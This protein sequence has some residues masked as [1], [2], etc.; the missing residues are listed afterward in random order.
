MQKEKEQ[1]E[2]L[3]AQATTMS[4]AMAEEI[5]SKS[6]KLEQERQER[7][8]VT[9]RL[10]EIERKLLHGAQVISETQQHE[11]ILRQKEVE[12]ERARVRLEC[13]N[14]K[15]LNADYTCS[16]VEE[17]SKTRVLR[18]KEEAQLEIAKKYDDQEGQVRKVTEKL[19]KLRDKY[20]EIRGEIEEVQS[21]FQQ[22]SKYNNRL[23]ECAIP[24][25]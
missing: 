14:L 3:K 15:K 11:I 8:S 20:K 23:N 24:Q 10:L 7:E 5:K 21:E 1:I 25:H 6:S 18:Q 16:Q 12:L 9:D 19:R 2:A 4:L 13:L 17:E 22:E